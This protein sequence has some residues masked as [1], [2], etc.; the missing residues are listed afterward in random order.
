MH[1]GI[2]SSAL[3][4][5]VLVFTMVSGAC[6]AP[7]PRVL[8]FSKTAAFRHASIETGIRAIHELGGDNGFAV[9]DTE[10]ATVFDEETLRTFDVVV[11]LSTTGD[12]L[13][14]V[15][16]ADFERFI[17]A[18]GGYVGIHAASDTEYGWPWYGDLVGAY[19]VGHPEIQQATLRVEDADHPAT[20]RLRLTW[21]R[22][23]RV[24]LTID[25]DSYEGASTGDPHRMAW[26]HEYDG[27]RSFYTA[28]GH[29][30]E[31]YDDPDFLRHLAGG[32]EYAL[33][34]RAGLD[35]SAVHRDRL[36]PHG[37]R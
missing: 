31:S 16:Q 17:Q 19:F 30:A 6:S 22:T 20:R 37:G 27:G 21:T 7:S 29:T 26:S 5:I 34:E 4:A 11:F 32:V 2:R 9:E 28:L 1:V 13:N 35:Y 3:A 10:D 25:E 12:V 36:S 14:A 23:D 15:Q 24:L 33:G 18:G 8:V